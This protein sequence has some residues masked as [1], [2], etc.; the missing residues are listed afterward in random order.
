MSSTVTRNRTR[1]GDLLN[2]TSTPLAV[3]PGEGISSSSG[4]V[5]PNSNGCPPTG[6]PAS[7][8]QAAVGTAAL[9]RIPCPDWVRFP[10]LLSI[11]A[12]RRSAISRPGGRS[13]SDPKVIDGNRVR[14]RVIHPVHALLVVHRHARADAGRSRLVHAVETGVCRCD[15]GIRRN[16]PA[17]VL[18][19]VD[20]GG[21]AV[22]GLSS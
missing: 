5:R 4:G 6:I 1:R 11:R 8:S 21:G 9:P 17:V 14:P 12:V 10:V 16:A 19:D 13:G 7:R 20:H 3:P 18:A 22:H 15:V 2:T